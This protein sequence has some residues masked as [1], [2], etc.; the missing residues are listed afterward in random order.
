[1]PLQPDKITDKIDDESTTFTNQMLQ[2]LTC[3]GKYPN[4]VANQKIIAVSHGK[5]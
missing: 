5:L 3:D 2:I 1:M 4:V